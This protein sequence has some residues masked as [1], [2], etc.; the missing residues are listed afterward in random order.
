V[1]N[2]R[3][4]RIWCRETLKVPAKTNK[5]R[6]RL[7]LNDGSCIRPRPEH[8]NHVWLRFGRDADPATRPPFVWHICSNP[9]HGCP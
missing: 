6:R 8:R 4:H 5:P 3:V 2:D 1:S 7:C 9:N